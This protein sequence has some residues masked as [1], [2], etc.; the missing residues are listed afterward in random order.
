MKKQETLAILNAARGK[1]DARGNFMI[2][3]AIDIL[4]GKYPK[5]LQD[6][7]AANGKDHPDVKKHILDTIRNAVK[8]ATS[9]KK[10]I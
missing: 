9:N 3:E 8:I 2:R 7:I 1:K 4:N 10:S 5:Y 6:F